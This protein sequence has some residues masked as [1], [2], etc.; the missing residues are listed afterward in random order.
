[1]TMTTYSD[2][3]FDWV[4]IEPAQMIYTLA[5]DRKR[6]EKHPSCSSGGFHAILGG[7]WFGI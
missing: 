6:F 7:K 1:M 3:N 2:S 5:F 4:K